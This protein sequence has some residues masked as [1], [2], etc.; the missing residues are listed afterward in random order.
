MKLETWLHFYLEEQYLITALLPDIPV[1]EAIGLL[2]RTRL[3]G[4]QIFV[5]GNGG[6]ASNASHFAQDMTKGASD[7]LLSEGKPGF[8]C[9]SLTDNVAWITA[10]GNDIDYQAIFSEQ[11]K[12][13]GSTQDV[14]IAISVSGT[15]ANLICAADQAHHMGIEVV[16][17]IGNRENPDN[18]PH[19]RDRSDIVIEI[20]NDH[21]GHVEDSMMTIL[22]ALAYYFQENA[23][24]I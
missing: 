20:N 18:K 13:L 21:F 9:V 4:G 12:K 22:H 14:F 7:S 24:D 5:A 16:S 23:G 17:I 19:L 1:I 8:R 2:N 3:K 11:L 6:S 15:S 10:L